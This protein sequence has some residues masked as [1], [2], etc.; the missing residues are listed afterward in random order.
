MQFKKR[1][2]SEVGA[3]AAGLQARARQLLRQLGCLV[4]PG[5]STPPKNRAPADQGT[6]ISS[7]SQLT[8]RQQQRPQSAARLT[9]PRWQCLPDADLPTVSLQVRYDRACQTPY[10]LHCLP[11]TGLTVGSAAAAGGD[12]G[13]AG[14]GRRTSDT[15]HLPS[16][17][18]TYT[19]S[20]A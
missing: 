3:A 4:Q 5:Q 12:H 11:V 6:S 18:S 15:W 10:T 14:S 2:T 16:Y 7:R 9:P 17:S 13:G 20:K 19:A 8:Q 1:T